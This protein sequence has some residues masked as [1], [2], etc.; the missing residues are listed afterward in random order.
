[1]WYNE[2]MRFN[3]FLFAIISVGIVAEIIL[4]T[5]AWDKYA[6]VLV[7]IGTL[8]LAGVTYY[9]IRESNKRER[10]RIQEQKDKEK[11]DRKERLL[12][13]I[14][15]WVSDVKLKTVQAN[16][17]PTLLE[18]KQRYDRISL[19][20][21]G[22]LLNAEL[23]N[24][25]ASENSIPVEKELNNVWQS[26]FFCSQ[27]AA[28]IAGNKPTDEQRHRWSKNALDIVAKIDQMEAQGN[29][30]DGEMYD[31]QKDL[32]EKVSICLKKLVKVEATL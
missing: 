15:E 27:L 8:A 14:I 9:S 17:P 16:V 26:A 12:N 19:A 24:L 13:E 1:M 10:N 29:L 3:N 32:L 5:L 21:S 23:M 30:T 4:I 2:G 7:A 6:E 20:I 22:A 28:R 11:R 18:R 25:R 31:G